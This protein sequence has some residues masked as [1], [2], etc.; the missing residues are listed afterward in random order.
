MPD[1]TLIVASTAPMAVRI[2]TI[3]P[4]AD[5]TQPGLVPETV[6]VV[7]NGT[8]HPDAVGGLG[9]THDVPAGMFHAWL[10]AHPHFAAV[11]SVLTPE[12][13]KTHAD[14]P[15]QHGFEPG[16]AATEAANADLA[17]KSTEPTEGLPEHEPPPPPVAA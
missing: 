4:A 15:L 3:D 7:I 17:T 2:H 10:A 8:G 13:F 14:A 11:L 6:P 9:I 5:P 12:Q 16:V 1:D